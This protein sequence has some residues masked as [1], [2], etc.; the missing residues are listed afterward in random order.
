MRADIFPGRASHGEAHLGIRI[1]TARI[2]RFTSAFI[3]VLFAVCFGSLSIRAQQTSTET[4]PPP[5]DTTPHADVINPVSNRIHVASP[6][7]SCFIAAI[8]AVDPGTNLVYIADGGRATPS[9]P[10]APY[11]AAAAP[12][13][14]SRSN[15]EE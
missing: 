3:C 2:H 4:F 6:G 1:Y 15:Q 11:P 13:Q 12:R 14:L 8:V 9:F 7:D 5:A 10:G